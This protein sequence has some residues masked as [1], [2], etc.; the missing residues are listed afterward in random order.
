MGVYLLII[1]G[2][3]LHYRG[4]YSVYD[5]AW[6][7][8]ALCRFAGFL[9]TYS[10]EI[11]VFTLVV[12]TLDRFVA[13]IFPFRFN[14]MTI[15]HA[16][17]VMVALWAGVAGVAAAPLVDVAYFRGFYGRSGVCL[18]LHITPERPPGWEYSV[19][20]FLALNF[21]LLLVIFIA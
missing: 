12:I 14:R 13:I 9:S 20:V 17:M 19:F 10:S 8:S 2:V 21:A 7:Q 16:R 1:A 3:D 15:R 6:R 11:S 18:A 5:S 4:V